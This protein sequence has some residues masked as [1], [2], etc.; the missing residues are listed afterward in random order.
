MTVR[1]LT[2]D[3][4]D[5]L[6]HLPD[7]SVHCVVTSP[8]YFGLRD[9]G[10]EPQ[11]WGGHEDCQH[12]WGE[13]ERGK[14]KDMLP[15]DKTASEGRSGTTAHQDGAA[16]NGGRFCVRCGAW[17]G[18][19]GLEP[20]M[21]MHIEHLVRIFREVRRVLRKDGT[22]WLNYGDA[23]AG[24]AN[25]R[26]AADTKALG[27]HDR[28]FRDKPISTVGGVFKPKDLMMMPAR[29]AM[30]LQAE[31]WWLR[32]EIVW[33]KPNPA[34]E[35]AKDRPTSA[36]EK[37]YLLTR[38][39][40]YFY[41]AGAVRIPE[42]GGATPGERMENASRRRGQIR[43]ITVLERGR[44]E[45]PRSRMAGIRAL[46]HTERS[47]G[48][49]V[50]GARRQPLQL[51][52]PT[53]ATSGQS[54]PTDTQTP[55]SPHFRRRWSSRASR[56]AVRQVAWCWTRSAVPAPWAWSPTAWAATRS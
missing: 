1:I 19:L 54:R 33:S 14:R 32:S 3:V 30:A 27:K 5:R 6:A 50:R 16:H 48:P 42:T 24:S 18:N 31:G 45:Q 53:S 12:E 38:S 7:E 41:D 40:R 29:V 21:D 56:R 11:V 4:F 22:L 46:D 52:V 17:L 37:V 39:A 2:G 49:G 15:L 51:A 34:P 25:G 28:T 8:P 55:I 20:T 44:N 43:T 35:G 36:H 9:Y 13:I 23:Y 47:I 10:L 26:S